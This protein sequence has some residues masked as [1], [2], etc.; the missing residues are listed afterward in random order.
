MVCACC[1]ASPHAASTPRQ[2]H[3]STASRTGRLHSAPASTE[4][5]F[6]GGNQPMIRARNGTAGRVVAR[7]HPGHRHINH[8]AEPDGQT[9]PDRK[10]QSYSPRR[11]P[12]SRLRAEAECMMRR[13][14]F[15]RHARMCE[16][17]LSIVTLQGAV[18]MEPVLVGMALASA[19]LH[20][21]WN[22]MVKARPDIGLAMTA[23]MVLAAVFMLPLLAAVGLPAAASLPWMLASTAI[24]TVTVTALLRGYAAAEF[25][26]VYPVSRAL[27]VLLVVPG[28]S[29]LFGERIG[30]PAIAGVVLISVALVVLAVGGRTS[31]S[32]APA[33]WGWITLAGLSTALY[34]LVDVQGVRVSGSAIAYGCCTS[35]LNALV[36]A[37][38]QRRSFPS[39]AAV[40]REAT[41][42]TPVAVA[43]VVSYLL[44]LHVYTVAP[45]ASAS[46]LRDTS[47]LFAVVLAVL[48]LKEKVTPLQGLALVLAAL[49]VPLLRLG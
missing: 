11:G 32:L 46:A 33:A 5:R 24:N 48:W 49:A 3:Q 27:S 25:G 39:L 43:S 10:C 38:R 42:M 41:A 36:M 18:S 14:A 35:V 2:N 17:R 7:Q 47:A 8:G 4:P 6:S 13:N 31:R 21:A 28:A 26:I 34:V 44:I 19:F 22:A 15:R 20:A 16:K 29:L 12:A 30:P 9:A 1:H 45:A 37:W 40:W 23:Q